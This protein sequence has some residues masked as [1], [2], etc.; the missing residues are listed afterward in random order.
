MAQQQDYYET[1]GVDREA[2]ADEIKL[3]YR[4]MA[5]KF[6]PDRNRDKPE[7]DAKFKACSEA[8]EVLSDPEKRSRYDRFGH[9]GLQ[10]AGLHDFSHMGFEDIFSMFNDILGGGGGVKIK[11][12]QGALFV[13]HGGAASGLPI[14]GG[15]CPLAPA[16]HRC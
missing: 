12:F 2:S 9:A 7:S 11:G 1:L 3:A 5:M 4:R 13:S 6:H 16:P 8:Y 15:G 10:G 14:I